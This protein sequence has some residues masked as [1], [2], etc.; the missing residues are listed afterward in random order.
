MPGRNRHRKPSVWALC[1]R[2]YRQQLD[3][4]ALVRALQGEAQRLGKN[5]Q[6]H[7]RVAAHCER[8]LRENET[9]KAV[10]AANECM[11]QALPRRNGADVI[12]TGE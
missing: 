9:L 7:A 12:S 1:N 6:I 11:A 10:I 4:R 3:V 2:I 8:L 5:Q